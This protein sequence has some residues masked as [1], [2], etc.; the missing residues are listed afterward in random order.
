MKKHRFPISNEKG[1]ALVM[2][3]VL[4]IIISGI[5]IFG[6]NTSVVEMWRSSNY[7]STKQAYYAAEAGIED[8]ISRLVAGT[9]SDSSSTTSTTWNNANT[10]SSASSLFTNWINSSNTSNSFTIEHRVIG[11]P[12]VV[13]TTSG[14]PHYRI[15][16][17][18]TSGNATRTIE[19]VIMLTTSSP[20]STGMVGC[21]SVTVHGS[22]A[23]DSYNSANGSYASQ[24][25][26]TDAQGNLYANNNGGVTTTNA[27][28]RITLSGSSVDIHGNV[29]STGPA[30][31]GIITENGDPQTYGT[32]T[33]HAATSSC[34][35]VN[36]TNLVNSM[37][38]GGGAAI[39][40]NGSF[41]APGTIN[42]TNFS[43]GSQEVYRITKPA[44]AGPFAVTMLVSGDFSIG[45]QAQLQIDAGVNVTIYSKGNVSIGGQGV[46]NGN[47]TPSSLLIYSSSTDTSSNGGIS[48]TGGSNFYG[49][50]YAPLSSTKLTGNTAFYGA[51]R[52]LTVDNG[53]TAGFHYDEQLGNLSG[54]PITGYT[55]IYQLR[56]YN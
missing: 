34:D 20:F 24:A 53:G 36:V 29:A 2:A 31:F 50:I 7:L 46:A 25:T 35:P 43:L 30:P 13:A 47:N 55:P 37:V 27:N 49:A 21:D 45:S 32:E 23:V 14:K 22:G 6:I 8:G 4:L 15:R 48:V 12:A 56:I 38:T 18:G 40:G 42:V 19:A 11:N 54:G 28:G 33:Q 44:G 39:S 1:I 52:G 3:L 5:G 16:S 51:I 17:I 26:Q 41:T 10:Y 9:V